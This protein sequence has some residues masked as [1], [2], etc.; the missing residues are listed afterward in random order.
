METEQHGR[1]VGRKEFV[2][3]VGERV[4]VM[5]GKRER[6]IKLVVPVVVVLGEE[7]LRVQDVAV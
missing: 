1:Q 2:Y 5:R 6:R 3:Q 4:V 7:I